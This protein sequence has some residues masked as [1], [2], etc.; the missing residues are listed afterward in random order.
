MIFDPA[1]GDGFDFVVACDAAH[2][3]PQ[4]FL[5]V[6]CDVPPA[7]FCRKNDVLQVADIR[8]THVG[9]YTIWRVSWNSLRPSGTKMGRGMAI[10]ARCA[11]L[12]SQRPYG[13]QTGKFLGGGDG[14][15]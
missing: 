10:P 3:G 8:M 13:T 4:L 6:S 11:G 12:F 7:I 5:H 9:D 2:V 1:D 15:G 14:R